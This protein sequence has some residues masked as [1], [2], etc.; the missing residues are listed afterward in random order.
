MLTVAVTD[1]AGMS[2]ARADAA[3]P[4]CL[5]WGPVS[6]GGP[7]RGGGRVGV[8]VLE[9]CWCQAVPVGGAGAALKSPGL[10]H[11]CQR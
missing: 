10:Q 3:L 11:I 1:G 8:H 9:L 2:H 5:A 6:D 4:P 7:I